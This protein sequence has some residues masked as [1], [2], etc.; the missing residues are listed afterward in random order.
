M[1]KGES[2]EKIEKLKYFYLVIY[3][4]QKVHSDFIFYV[5]SIASR[6]SVPALRNCMNTSRKE[7]FSLRAQ[8]LA[9]QVEESLL[10]N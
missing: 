9:H 5:V 2:N 10:Q 8:P 1:Y 4:T 3:W 6:T 7:F